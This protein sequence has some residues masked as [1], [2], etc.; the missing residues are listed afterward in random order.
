MKKI[1]LFFLM[2]AVVAIA[3]VLLGAV[4]FTNKSANL[5]FVMS[6]VTALAG[7]EVQEPDYGTYCRCKYGWCRS[8]NKVSFR[9]FCRGPIPETP[10]DCSLY[11]SEGCDHD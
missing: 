9:K 1:D 11:T 10:V 8:G 6:D 2:G 5:Q 7:G 3:L 4:R